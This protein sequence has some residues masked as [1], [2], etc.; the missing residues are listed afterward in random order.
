MEIGLKVLAEHPQTRERKHILSAYFTFVALDNEGKPTEVPA[1]IP[2]SKIEHRR[3]EE[4]DSRR[5]RRRKD[6]EERSARRLE[7]GF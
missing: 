7:M 5:E 4:A 6:K 1:V 3:Y 2:E